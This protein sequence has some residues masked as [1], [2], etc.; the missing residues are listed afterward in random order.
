M[1]KTETRQLFTLLLRETTVLYFT[2]LAF[3]VCPPVSIPF[4]EKETNMIARISSDGSWA[5]AD[6]IRSCWFYWP[7]GRDVW[8]ILFLYDKYFTAEGFGYESFMSILFIWR[9]QGT[10]ARLGNLT[11]LRKYFS[12]LIHQI[13][14]QWLGVFCKMATGGRR[15]RWPTS[16]WSIESVRIC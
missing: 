15:K 13:V 5:S 1:G 2:Y 9:W 14:P 16:S 10:Q 11:G 3:I 12:R 4:H 6:Q 7:G 8:P